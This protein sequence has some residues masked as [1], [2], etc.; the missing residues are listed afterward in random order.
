MVR[1]AWAAW[2]WSFIL[3]SSRCWSIAVM[4]DG[5]YRPEKAR[6]RQVDQGALDHDR[7]QLR[8]RLGAGTLVR[9]V[10]QGGRN[11][12]CG[13]QGR[14]ID[15]SGVDRSESGSDHRVS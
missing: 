5:S 10:V 8:L 12:Q 15:G 1:W 4:T 2:P 6:K 3:A 9:R 7:R 11:R 13:G 14:Q